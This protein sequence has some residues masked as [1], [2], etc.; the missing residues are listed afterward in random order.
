MCPCQT[1]NSCQAGCIPLRGDRET[2]TLLSRAPVVP[3]SPGYHRTCI[4]RKTRDNCG[5]CTDSSPFLSAVPDPL[6][7]KIQ[8]VFP[9]ILCINRQ[10]KKF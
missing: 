1:N 10:T 2:P 9:D 3:P 8:Q 6:P 7:N 5:V 4:L